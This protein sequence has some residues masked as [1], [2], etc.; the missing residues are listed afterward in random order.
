MKEYLKDITGNQGSELAGKRIILAV[1]GSIA[2]TESTK[3]ARCL[4]R[5]GAEVFPVMTSAARDIIGSRSLEWATGNPVVTEITGRVEHLQLAGEWPGAC[6]LLLVAPATANTIG[7]IAAAV[8]DTPVTTVATAAIG[9]GIPVMIAP[10]MHECMYRHPVV[11]ENI[12]KLK[13]IGIA[14]IDPLVEEGKAKMAESSVILEHVIRR[15]ST[16]CLKGRRVLVSAGATVE[17]IDAVRIV[18][19]RSSGAMGCALAR[20]AFR[21]GAHVTM[22]CGRMEVPP[23]YGALV[24]H[25][26]RTEEMRK[27]V[28]DAVGAQDVF[29]AAAAVADFRPQHWSEGKRDSGEGISLTLVPTEK[30]LDEVKKAAPAVFL[31]AFKAEAGISRD[32]LAAR[33]RERMKKAGADMIV[34]NEVGPSRGM[35]T[36]DNEVIIIDAGGELVLPLAPKDLI[37]AGIWDE[38]EKRLP[39]ARGVAQ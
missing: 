7:K 16:S 24:V 14:F 5:H 6:H 13:S 8:D 20:E 4:M 10:G 32:E 36:P 11:M 38:V 25:A 31:V 35:E 9:S 21:R 39:A 2:A 30:I 3:V 37:A 34:A 27:A 1:T 19:N 33:A 12:E 28:L 23:P 17:P 29:L 26:R 22:I 15:F 18:T